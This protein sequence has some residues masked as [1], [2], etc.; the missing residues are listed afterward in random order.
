MI[1]GH[2]TLSTGDYENPRNILTVAC[3]IALV[4]I[5]PAAA[6]TNPEPQSAADL[7][8]QL[9]ALRPKWI[10]RRG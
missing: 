2:K 10:I 6:Q 3:L 7:R 9:D 5:F 4:T 8:R 1:K